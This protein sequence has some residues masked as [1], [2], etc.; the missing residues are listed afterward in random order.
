MLRP[1]MPFALCLLLSAFG[2]SGAATG[3][4]TGDLE[5]LRQRALELVNQERRDQGLE[6]LTLGASLNEA[7]Q[8]HAEDML[9]R[10]Y[11]SHV[12]PEGDTVRDRYTAAGGSRWKVAAE[13][14]ARCQGC[15]SPPTV[16]RVEELHQGWMNSPEH[17][18]NILRRGLDTF[19]FGIVVGDDRT[20]YAVQTFAGAG[21]S[22]DQQPQED[23]SAL[24]PDRQNALAVQEIN[25]AREAQGVPAL[26]TD[27]ALAQAAANLLPEQDLASFE[28]SR[29]DNLMQALPDDART[30]WSSLG[31]IVGSCGGCGTVPNA[32][33]I[34]SFVDQ[35]LDQPEYRDRLLD[36]RFTDAG[37]IVR[38]DG[39]GLKRALLV[40]GQRR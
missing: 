2:M 8:K 7:A 16:S 5:R 6:T 30:D 36:P 18:E 4:E 35:W 17:R 15:D 32:A 3:A 19:G 31:V 1:L 26:E 25:K 28:A 38:A 33:D 40:L 13:N 21:T 23:M 22:R 37:F 27:P 34:R 29:L 14:I 20:L 11:Y 24:A 9:A 39:D 12:S 10:N